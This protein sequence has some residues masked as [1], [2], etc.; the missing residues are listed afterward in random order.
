MPPGSLAFGLLGD[1]PYSD[2]QAAKLDRLID[3][4]N[5]DRLAFVV[6]LGDVGTRAQACRDEW[7]QAR[8]AQFGK[9]RH[10]F[11]LIPGDNEWSDCHAAG[12]DPLARLR[13]WREM[14]CDFPEEL[15][16]E[17]QA[18]EYCEHVRWRTGD[19][20]FVTLNVPGNNNNA[21]MPDEV[22]ARMKS[23]M[24]WIDAAEKLAPARLVLLA[25]ANPFVPRTGYAPLLARLERLGRSMPGR[26]Y[27]LHGDTHVYRDDEPFAGLRRLEV[28]GAPFVS[29]VR[30]RQAGDGLRFE[31]AGQY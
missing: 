13:R 17:R 29:W 22:E 10:P 20:L 25:Q 4:L 6:H 15:K 28:W 30:V 21:R 8:K 3:D 18:G 1:T 27:L 2:D 7:L 9:I 16:I 19:T 31:P 26:A 23:V 14:F 12:R 11:V 24:A 5:R